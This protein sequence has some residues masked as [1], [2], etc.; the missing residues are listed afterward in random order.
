MSGRER[1]DLL[2]AERVPEHNPSQENYQDTFDNIT[3]QPD[4]RKLN[5]KGDAIARDS[6]DKSREQLAGAEKNEGNSEKKAI[7]D[8]TAGKTA[9]VAGAAGGPT[10]R[11]AAKILGKIRTKEGGIGGIIAAVIITISAVGFFSTFLAPVAFIEGVVDDLNDQLA[12]L[13]IRQVKAMR[14]KVSYD[15]KNQAFKGCSKLSIR[16]KAKSLSAKQVQTFKDFG[17]EPKGRTI[18]FGSIERTFPTTYSYGKRSY[19]PAE[20]VNEMKT[21]DP[22]RRDFKRSV[23]MKFNGFRDSRFIKWTQAKLGIS[24]KKPVLTGNEA[25]RARKLATLETTRVTAETEFVKVGTDPDGNDRY[26]ISG[27][28]VTVT[29]SKAEVDSITAQYGKLSTM[30]DSVGTVGLQA[31]RAVSVVGFVDMACSVKNMIGLAATTTK[32]LTMY[33]ASQYAAPIWAMTHAEKANDISAADSAALHSF[34]QDTDNRQRIP[35]TKASFEAANIVEGQNMPGNIGLETIEN[36]DFGE[37]VMDSPLYKMSA[38]GGPPIVDETSVRYSLGMGRTTLLAAVGATAAIMESILSAGSCDIVQNWAVRGISVIVGIVAAILSGSSSVAANVAIMAVLGAAFMAI[39]AALMS[40]LVNDIV[41]KDI[42]EKPADK[43]ALT[44]TG[45]AGITSTSSQSRGM[46][47][48]NAAEI[49]QYDNYQEASIRDYV[50]IEREDASFFDFKNQYS[51]TG[52]AL[53]ALSDY[54]PDSYNAADLVASLTNLQQ[55]AVGKPF[56]ESAQAQSYADRFNKCDDSSYKDLGI[57]ADIQCNIRYV[58]RDQDLN[59]DTEQVIDYMESNGYV[60]LDPEVGESVTGLPEG[61]TPPDP[62]QST[63]FITDMVSGIKNEFYNQRSFGS[64]PEA[65]EYGKFLDYCVYRAMP[66]GV[67]YEETSGWG[68]AEREWITGEN[69]RLNTEKISN[70]R[71]FTFDVTLHDITE[72]VDLTSEFSQTGSTGET[73]PGTVSGD[74]RSLAQQILDL[75]KQGKIIFN[76]LRQVDVGTRTTPELQLVDIAAGKSPAPATRCRYTAPSPIVPDPKLLQFM[77]NFG[78]LYKYQVNSLFAQCH[79]GPESQHHEGAAVDFGCPLNIAI[80]DKVGEPLGV[81]R[82][83][84]TCSGDNH[85]HY[86]VKG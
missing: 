53:L 29:F 18:K 75:E 74:V 22:L 77:V 52:G 68:A 15:E 37:N 47:P 19:K 56:G 6:I 5:D 76:V 34:Y 7:S 36:P 31:L 58:M 81:R 43:A 44:W 2:E 41:P 62:R 84:E 54:V 57:D 27:G 65:Q 46:I 85:W 26:I 24:K 63:K 30:M 38:Q 33:S 86:S 3:N 45:L 59:R 61:Y 10:G 60:A 70:F 4:M 13:D 40:A 21:N 32:V 9:M 20:F 14:A 25:E 16:C 67:T 73:V 8:T 51:P 28:D 82:N 69:C 1:G 72:V 42:T 71:V 50:A 80:G 12:A 49:T 17:I 83:W 11:V 35:S 79:S 55:A 66:Y 48:A 78:K 23:N 64:T 39:N